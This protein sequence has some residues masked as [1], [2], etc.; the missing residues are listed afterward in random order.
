MNKKTLNKFRHILVEAQNPGDD[1][2]NEFGKERLA[3]Y[4]KEHVHQSADVFLAGLRETV[5]GFAGK[6]HDDVTLVVIQS[7]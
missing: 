6:F 7:R 5:K 2:D 3:T 1:E 4:V